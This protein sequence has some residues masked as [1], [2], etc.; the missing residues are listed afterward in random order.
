MANEGKGAAPPPTATGVLIGLALAGILLHFSLTGRY[1]IFRDELYY[2]ACADHLAWGY[3][4]HPPL[5][6]ALLAAVRALLGDSLFALRL[7]PVLL[8]GA[9]VVVTGLLARELGGRALAQ[10]LA[11]LSVLLAPIVLANGTFYSMNALELLL[12]PSCFLL[13][14]RIARHGGRGRWLW[15][16][17]LLGLAV[18]NKLGTAFLGVGL[19]MAIALTRLRRELLTPWLWAGVAL[20][21]LVV[22]PHVVWQVTHGWPFLEFAASA[23]A[24]KMVAMSLPDFFFALVLLGG[25]AA[26]PLWLGGLVALLALP[27][28]RPFRVAGVTALVALG[29]IVLAGGKP[30]YAAPLLPPLLA[31]G[32]VLLERL[33]AGGRRWIAPVAVGLVGLTG[34]VLLPMAVPTLPPSTYVAYAAR[35]GVAPP[36]D[37]RAPLG[38]LPQHFADRFGWENLAATVG[39]VYAALP[40]EERERAAV[41]ASNY[42]EAGAIDFFGP[43]YGLPKAI[44]PHNAYWHWGPRDATGELVIAVGYPRERLDALFEQVEERGRV[45]S[46]WAMPYE[47]DLP[48]FVCRGLRAPIDVAWE[49]AKRFI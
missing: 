1:G 15:L 37:E 27:R 16:G 21:A 26:V 5:S 33:S 43:R 4:D 44:C 8:G 45:V 20:A 12:W 39:R 49:A 24:G 6:I 13:L 36:R 2:L 11:A 7:V 40:P 48:V 30:Y 38:S 47:T 10:G 32:A 9:T 34:L 28:L 18:E 17:L 31:A 19:V 25:P 3:V 29:A 23:R 46:E 41:L 42:G 14:A 35:L 22:A